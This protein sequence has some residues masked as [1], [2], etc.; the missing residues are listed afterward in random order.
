[1]QKFQVGMAIFRE[2]TRPDFKHPSM[3]HQDGG[4]FSLTVFTTVGEQYHEKMDQ[5]DQLFTSLLKYFFGIGNPDGLAARPT[6]RS[7][8]CGIFVRAE[9]DLKD[10]NI[11]NY[12]EAS[13]EELPAKFR[14]EV[15]LLGWNAEKNMVATDL[16]KWT[17]AKKPEG[18]GFGELKFVKKSNS[19]F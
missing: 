17:D 4:Y 8:V 13:S 11:A 15:W 2:G 18:F 6:V 9:V 19:I 14:F 3:S 7:A 1:L 12:D 5:L 10:K 16:A